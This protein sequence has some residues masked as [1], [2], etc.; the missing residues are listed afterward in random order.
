[1]CGIILFSCELILQRMKPGS[2]FVIFGPTAEQSIYI[3]FL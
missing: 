1:M 3:L 2:F